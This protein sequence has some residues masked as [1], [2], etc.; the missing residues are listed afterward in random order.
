MQET[1]DFDSS[2]L[3]IGIFFIHFKNEAQMYN[4][5]IIHYTHMHHNM[6]DHSGH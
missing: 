5:E 4:P 1:Y 3:K 6:Q 2:W